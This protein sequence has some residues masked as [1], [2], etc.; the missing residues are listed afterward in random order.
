MQGSI[1]V[2]K[3]ILFLCF[4]ILNSAFFPITCKMRVSPMKGSVN[5]NF[6]SCD[7]DGTHW[8]LGSTC[9]YWYTFNLQMSQ[10]YMNV[11]GA[12]KHVFSVSYEKHFNEKYELPRSSE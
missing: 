3:K 11:L 1:L 7:L 5:V 4:M 2:V 8:H 6:I 12:K 10:V 9:I